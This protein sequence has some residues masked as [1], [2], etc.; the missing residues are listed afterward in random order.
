MLGSRNFIVM[1]SRLSIL[2]CPNQL[3][4]KKMS[5]H[6]S[7]ASLLSSTRMYSSSNVAVIQAVLLHLLLQ[8]NAEM[9]RQSQDVFTEYTK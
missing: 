9:R 8:G 4:I 5:L 3:S 1:A 2:P 6:L 7:L